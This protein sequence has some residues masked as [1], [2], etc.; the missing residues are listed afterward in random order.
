MFLPKFQPLQRHVAI[1]VL[2]L[3]ISFSPISQPS[4]EYLIKSSYTRLSLVSVSRPVCVHMP[5]SAHY[6]ANEREVR[7][8][9]GGTVHIWEANYSSLISLTLHILSP[10]IAVGKMRP[11]VNPLF[12]HSFVRMARI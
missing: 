6:A 1:A 8:C 2:F 11:K 10:L 5:G 3:Y 12:K 7:G 4:I 9:Q